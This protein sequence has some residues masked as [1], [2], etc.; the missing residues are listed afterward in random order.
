MI[1]GRRPSEL[2]DEKLTHPHVAKPRSP[3][4]LHPRNG[5]TIPARNPWPGGDAG[6]GEMRDETTPNGQKQRRK[7]WMSQIVM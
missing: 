5:L 3:S 2:S 6:Q 7:W 1:I 4:S